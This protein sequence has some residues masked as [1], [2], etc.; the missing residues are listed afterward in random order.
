M[1]STYSPS[2]FANFSNAPSLSD[3]RQLPPTDFFSRGEAQDGADEEMEDVD[4]G[5]ILRGM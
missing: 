5:S 4:G 1:A 2:T 3:A